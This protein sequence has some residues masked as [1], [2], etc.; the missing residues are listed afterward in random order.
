MQ[1]ISNRLHNNLVIKATHKKVLSAA[2]S[3]HSNRKV[4]PTCNVETFNALQSKSDLLHT[5][6]EQTNDQSIESTETRTL[7]EAIIV[8]GTKEK[9]G[10]L[11]AY[12]EH[13]GRDFNHSIVSTKKGKIE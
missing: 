3:N 13:F 10:I 5:S 8:R 11:D 7:D 1:D 4:H 12:E 6:P 9:K 2:T